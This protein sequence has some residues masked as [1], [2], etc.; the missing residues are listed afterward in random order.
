MTS[1]DCADPSQS[2]PVRNQT[3][4]ALQALALFNNPFVVRQAAFLADRVAAEAGT[5]DAQLSRAWSLALSQPP[6]PGELAQLRPYAE[7][8]GLAA[9]CRLILNTNAFFFVD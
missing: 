8:H 4:T 7:A 2:V 9:A 6:S 3:I 1:L 5:L